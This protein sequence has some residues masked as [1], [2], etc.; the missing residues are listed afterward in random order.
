M[1]VLSHKFE[2]DNGYSNYKIAK[3]IFDFFLLIG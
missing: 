3:V 1:S 2:Y